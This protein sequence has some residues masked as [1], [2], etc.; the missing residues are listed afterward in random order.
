MRIHKSVKYNLHNVEQDE[1]IHSLLQPQVWIQEI[2]SYVLMDQQYHCHCE[3]ILRLYF[4]R[5]KIEI[6]F[7]QILDYVDHQ[8]VAK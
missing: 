1:L 5:F 4:H 3:V 7:E 6:L 8:M 2:L